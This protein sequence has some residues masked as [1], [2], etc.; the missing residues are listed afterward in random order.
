MTEARFRPWA[1]HAYQT[2]PDASTLNVWDSLAL[3]E[4]PA[5]QQI[6]R[7]VGQCFRFR[8]TPKSRLIMY[9]KVFV[10]PRFLAP[11]KTFKVLGECQSLDRSKDSRWS[12]EVDQ[13]EGSWPLPCILIPAFLHKFPQIITQCRWSLNISS[14]QHRSVTFD[15]QGMFYKRLFEYAEKLLSRKLLYAPQLPPLQTQR[16]PLLWPIILHP[17]SRGPPTS[18]S[19]SGEHLGGY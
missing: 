8:G 4:P 6:D 13:F 1:A 5:P 14:G 17:R 9:S 18:S 12:K 3:S 16:H 10:S 11:S 15:G 19:L 2:T 7:N